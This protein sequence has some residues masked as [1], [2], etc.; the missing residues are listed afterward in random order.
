MT[1]NV[2]RHTYYLYVVLLI[3]FSIFLR[4]FMLTNQSLWI[5]EGLSLSNSD[6]STLT[7]SIATI[8][9]IPNSDRFQPLYYIVLFW[10]RQLFGDT[11]FAL[12]SLSALLGI[13]S[14]IVLFFTTLRIYGKNHALWSSLILAFSSFAIYYSQEVRNYALLIFLASLQLYFFSPILTKDRGKERTFRLFFWLFV[15]L[16]LFG[17]VTMFPFTAALCLSHLVISRNWKQWLQW[18]LPVALLSLPVILFYLSLPGTTEPTTILISRQGFP[19]IQNALF[20]IYGILVGTTYG[21][22]M[23]ELRSGNKLQIV[24]NYW[25]QLLLLAIA[26]SV[27]CLALVMVLGKYRKRSKYSHANA[28]VVCILTTSFFLG[29]CL[30]LVTQMNWVPRHSFYL[31]LLLAMLIPSSFLQ[32]YKHRV[33]TPL[34]SKYSLIAVI[35]LLILNIYSLSNY[36]FNQNYW[37][38]DYRSAIQYVLKHRDSSEQSILFWANPRLLKYYGNISDID[39]RGLNQENFTAEKVR[40]LTSN[41]NT[42]FIL[43]NREFYRIPQELLVGEMSNLY[44]LESEVDF[45]YFHVYRYRLNTSEYRDKQKAIAF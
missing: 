23:E 14:V 16:G 38:D 43:V 25:P 12:R 3:A 40:E 9:N 36:Y 26:V 6:V 29:F 27:I 10:W 37:R 24:L 17:S 42:V 31:C 2:K 13:G 45:P 21:P 19:I 5:D 33:N 28:L 22:S 32:R 7:E 39:G 30:A 1:L 8:R 35:S 4:F 15:V 34:L 20:V 44:L 11:E 41:A 18:W